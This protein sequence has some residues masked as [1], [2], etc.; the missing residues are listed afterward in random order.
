MAE[1][2]QPAADRDYK[3]GHERMLAL[4]SGLSLHKP[5]LRIRIAGTNGKGSTAVMLAEALAA[6]G[7]RTGLYTSPHIHA[8]HERIRI[9]GT[10]V[11]DD[12]LH[13]LLAL[14]MP[15]ARACG[16]SYFEVATAL[17]LIHFSQQKVDIEILEA[18][19]GAR[20]DATT[21]VPADLALI[22]PIALDH[23]AWLG[24]S[25][26][27]VAREKAHVTQGCRLAISAAQTDEVEKTIRA[28][29][30]DITMLDADLRWPDLAMAGT[31]QQINAGL[32]FAAVNSIHEQGWI[33]INLTKAGEAI[34][35]SRIP[36]RLQHIQAGMAHVWVDAAHNQHAV[37]ALLPILPELADPFDAI[38]VWT[39]EDRSLL[40]SLDMLRPYARRLIS[41]DIFT[42][43]QAGDSASIWQL[44][45]D[46]IHARPD[47]SFLVLGSFTTVAAILQHLESADGTE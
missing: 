42:P 14:L 9:N 39:R 17:A 13:Q 11:S 10:P 43:G 44:L 35:R 2:G 40:D 47:G 19:V 31:H 26:T 20:L 22:T 28:F 16:A 33:E 21:A 3:P 8:F 5:R 4:L 30:H 23:Q 24:D 45:Q 18:G 12:V 25:L 27:E 41:N 1:L 15:K 29:C 36:G 6:S 46:A 32:A 37:Q 34:K 7:H 38:F